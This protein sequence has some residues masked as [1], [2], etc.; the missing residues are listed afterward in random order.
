[1][2]KVRNWLKFFS[3]SLLGTA[4][5]LCGFGEIPADRTTAVQVIGARLF[6]DASLSRKADVSCASCHLPKRAFADGRAVAVGTG[7]RAGTRNTPSLLAVGD[8]PYFWD[9]RTEQLELVM[10]QPFT[11]PV[12]MGLASQDDL[13][14]RLGGNK[15]YVSAF[16][17]AFPESGGRITIP[18]VEQALAAYVRS[19]GAGTS[20]YDRYAT[21]RDQ[22]ALTP[23]ARH[24]LA[25]FQGSAG[26][27]E[28]H[29]MEGVRPRFT[30][31]RFH[32]TLIN[33]VLAPALPAVAVQLAQA[34]GDAAQLSQEIES[35]AK[36]SELGRYV[37]THDPKDI[38][39]FRTPSL[40]DVALTAPYMHDGSMASLRE[41][42][43]REIY[44][45]NL[46]SNRPNTLTEKDRQDLVVF[47]ESLSELPADRH[48]AARR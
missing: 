45:R 20:S 31:D 38:G 32:S 27:A 43:D 25:L 7:H 34:Q 47:L 35:D 22:N 29:R 41:A 10:P 36:I 42:V 9:G 15:A 8:G 13:L 21:G 26:C 2:I 39:S 17:K 11:N 6:A 33:P 48:Q 16:S 18:M 46:Q 1:M 3:A 5:L 44:Y 19:L 40:R 12:E 30:D 23:E 4:P 14:S 37:V 28:C 24:G